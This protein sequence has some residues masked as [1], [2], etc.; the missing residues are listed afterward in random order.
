MA[1]YP[2]SLWASVPSEK[3]SPHS[4]LPTTPGDAAREPWLATVLRSFTFLP[5]HIQAESQSL[6]S[7]A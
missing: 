5:L 2:T 4:L 1:I 7:T 3:K 6:E